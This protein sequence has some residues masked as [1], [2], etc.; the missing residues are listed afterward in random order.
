METKQLAL[1]GEIF[2]H[3]REQNILSRMSL[4]SLTERTQ[5]VFDPADSLNDLIRHIAQVDIP[6]FAVVDA[7]HRLL[8][9]VTFND[10][11]GRIFNPEAHGKTL[12]KDLLRESPATL[13]IDT[14]MTKV[15]NEFDRTQVDYLPV[16]DEDRRFVGF[17][18]KSRLFERYRLQVAQVKDIYEDQ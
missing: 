10:I 1:S 2:T 14:P 17:V 3:R 8:G 18:S 15:I 11:R 6:V 16:I 13:P 9:V 12:L 4:G 7:G 5:Q